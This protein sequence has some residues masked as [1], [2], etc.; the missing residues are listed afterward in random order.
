MPILGF[1]QGSY[2]KKMII[3]GDTIC[4]VT[5]G[6]LIKVNKGINELY[7]LRETNRLQQKQNAISDSMMGQYDN[8]VKSKDSV[9][10]L[11]NQQLVLAENRY[12]A[13]EEMNNTLRSKA[14]K[15]TIIAGGFGVVIGVILKLLF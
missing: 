8:I 13:L 11:T 9:I 2:P 4:A 1:S 7:L 12:I 10:V 3:N 15:T 5:S 6:Q 14:K